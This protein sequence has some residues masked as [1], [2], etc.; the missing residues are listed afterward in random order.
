MTTESKNRKNTSQQNR[1]PIE[2]KVVF[3][4]KEA[5]ELKWAKTLNLPK[6]RTE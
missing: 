4:K 5:L 3:L 1:R 6:E 2:K